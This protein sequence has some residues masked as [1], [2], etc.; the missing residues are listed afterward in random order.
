MLVS[1]DLVGS[2]KIQSCKHPA[3]M[4]LKALLW[5]WHI[6]GLISE[7][8]RK[9]E[10][11]PAEVKCYG[12]YDSKFFFV[13]KPHLRRQAFIDFYYKCFSSAEKELFN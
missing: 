5:K 13:S 3:S 8:I 2:S 10:Q 12:F 4:Q 6:P 11:V 7:K 1:T 9:Q